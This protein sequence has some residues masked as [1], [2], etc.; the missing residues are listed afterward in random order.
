MRSKT[1]VIRLSTNAQNFG[2][3]NMHLALKRV[4]YLVR[5]KK[6]ELFC[7]AKEENVGS[8]DSNLDETVSSF[9]HECLSVS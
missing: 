6:N 2:M 1:I 8:T 4:K 3:Y 7:D 5:L 9:L